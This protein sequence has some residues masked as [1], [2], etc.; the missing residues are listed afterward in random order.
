MK[1]EDNNG[2]MREVVADAAAWR[3]ASLL[4][5][6]PRPE[7]RRELSAIR[8]EIADEELLSCADD[9]G[10]ATE[11]NYHALFGPGGTVS[12]REVSYCGFEDPGHLM[13]EL[14][15]FY[16]AFSYVPI[17][18]DPIDHICVEAG[19][20]SYL[21]LKEAY[22]RSERD[23]EGAA[24]TTEARNRFLRQHISRS[25]EGIFQRLGHASHYLAKV[26]AWLVRR[27]QSRNEDLTSEA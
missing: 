15:A 1:A 23:P 6:R 7:W 12:P 4:L 18:E 22:A 16:D 21:F 13:A 11:E 9:A 19:F 17:R 26:S 2:R 10:N 5:E 25:A 3:L 8:Q 27:A 24:V 20:V 14:Q